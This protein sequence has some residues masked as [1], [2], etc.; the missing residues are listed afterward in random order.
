M[1]G[2]VAI[3]CGVASAVMAAIPL[4]WLGHGLQ[5]ETAWTALL[6]GIVVAWIAFRHTLS[7][8]RSDPISLIG[9]IMILIY[10]CASARAYFWLIYPSGDA[11]KILSPNNLGDL[12]LHLS[13][14]RWLAVA[15]YWWPA[16]PILAGDPLRYPLGSDL[17]NALLLRVGVPAELGLVWCGV[18]G[19]TLTGIALWRWGRGV[20]MAALLFSGGCCSI[21]YLTQ[22]WGADAEASVQW[23]NLFLA[24]FVTQ[25]GFLFALP[26]GLLLLSAWRE[27]FFGDGKRLIPLSI[28]ALLLAALPLF[29]IHAALFLGVAMT[30]LW[31]MEG[32]SRP[33][34]GRLALTAWPLMAL[35]GWL[36]TSGAGGPSAVHALGLAPGW[37]GDGSIGFWLWN[38]GIS[39]P[40]A[41]VFCFLLMRRG[42]SAEARAFVWPAA[43]VFAA[44]MIV[45]FAPWPWDNT[46]LMLWS[47]L[48][49]APFLW[50][51]L[52]ARRAL[53]IR[54]LVAVLLF[55]SGALTLAAG[56]DGRHGYDLVKRADLENAAAL[57]REVP[58]GAVIACAPEY[59]QPVLMLGHPVVCGYEGHLWSHG[60]DYKT[61]WDALNAVMNGESDWREKARALG[62]SYI[63]WGDPEKNRW[64]DSKLPWVKDSKPSLHPLA[65]GE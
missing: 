20:A 33:V 51:E 5:T 2:V 9:W 59:N 53:F 56:L 30:G 21:L 65:G 8:R 57:L 27:E 43:I 46:K 41:V 39:L 29:S 63:F 62:V 50:Q 37:M 36:V 35:C 34:I 25:R 11:W 52:F 12:A 24:L 1:R 18:I 22:G 64:P 44:C 58:P 40:L 3:L 49:I 19:A 38:F 47:W 23:K 61:R 26:V 10:A 32:A 60:L 15:P 54:V 28:Q 31:V 14:I 48:V 6:I 55:G 7:M 16:S 4:A 17:F 13:F 42:S 45:R